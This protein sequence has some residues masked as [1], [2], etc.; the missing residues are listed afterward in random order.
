MTAR[1]LGCALALG[2]VALAGLATSAP[3]SRTITPPAR[4][5]VVASE[6]SFSLSRRTIKTGPAVI[7]LTNFGED[8]HDLYMRRLARRAVT[9]KVKETLPEHQKILRA[10]LAP[11]RFVLW[12]SIADHRKR[13]MEAHLTVTKRR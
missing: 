5:Q 2:G 7:E 9:L 1:Q 4:V 6:F 11:G 8:P 13:G 3:A 12:C 10:R